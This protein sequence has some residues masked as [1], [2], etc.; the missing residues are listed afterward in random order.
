MRNFVGAALFGLLLAT[1]GAV[2]AHA[3]TD[4]VSI[5]K[6]IAVSEGDSASDIV[7]V[8]CNVVVHGN[9]SGGVVAV[10]GGVNIDPSQSVSGDMVVIGGDVNLATGASVQ[11]DLVVV[12]GDLNLAPEAA[13]HGDRE[14]FA[15]RFWLLLPFAPFLIVF[16][17]VWLAIWL[18]R[19]NTYRF[20]VYPYGRGL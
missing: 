19:R 12:G 1:C 14:V 15:G 5:G 13:V 18:I 4:R 8:F 20:P 7:C 11:G 10:L 6:D 16:G 9:V 17:F 2:S 3:S